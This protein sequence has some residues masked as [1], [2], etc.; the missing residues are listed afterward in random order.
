MKISKQSIAGVF[1]IDSEPFID[2]RGAFRRHFCKEEFKKIGIDP[3]VEQANVSENKFAFTLRGFHYQ[4]PPF[5]EGKTLSCLH[6][7][8]FDI[9]VDLREDSET[10]MSWISVE[11][12]YENRRSLHV[13]PGCANAF[14]TMEDNSLIQYYCSKSY[15][16]SAERGI[17]YD[18]PAFNF[19]WPVEPKIISEKDQNHP[20]FKVS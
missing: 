1:V 5:G 16:P 4:L 11:L 3:I 8:I 12:S 19:S 7:K 2:D 10:F 14:L 15:E 17:R 18:D 13:P 6:G 9:V 20:N